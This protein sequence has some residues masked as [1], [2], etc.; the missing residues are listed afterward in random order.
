MQNT[1]QPAG[2]FQLDATPPRKK[3]TA[4]EKREAK[5]RAEA[6]RQEKRRDPR[7][8]VEFVDPPPATT[9]ET[10]FRHAHWRDKRKRVRQ[11][12]IDAATGPNQL[13]A[14]DNCGAECTVEYC[15]EEKRYRLKANYCKNRHCEPCMKA[16]SNLL[17]MNL[18]KKVADNPGKQF[19]FI[20]LTLR[21]TDE[22]LAAQLDR[23]NECFKKLRNS[24]RWKESQ[25][26][27][28]AIIEVKYNQDTGEWHPHLHIVAEGFFLHHSD[29]SADWLKITGDSFKVDIR[30]IKSARDASYYVAKYVSKGTN[31]QLW[32]TPHIAE[33]WVRTMKGRRTCATYG[34][35][36]GLKLLEKPPQTGEWKRVDTLDNIARAAARGE[37]WA[38]RLI[39]TLKSDLQYNPH[40]KRLPKAKPQP[41]V[42]T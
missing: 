24:K 29:L 3:T 12:L 1:T 9:H 18:Q 5:A 36:R 19:R 41:T 33:E 34:T 38:I 20:T 32:Y 27:G 11:A 15:A 22:P 30:A 8:K 7:G 14:F 21:H 2:S 40:K 26:G 13:T 25:D 31:D 10:D 37:E 28:A 6:R 42:A 35:W 39:D 16:K 4:I 17:A 23:L